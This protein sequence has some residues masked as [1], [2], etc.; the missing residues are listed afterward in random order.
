MGR[1]ITHTQ[2]YTEQT[3]YQPI[4]LVLAR[5]K[6]EK[7]MDAHEEFAG[8]DVGVQRFA[9]QFWPENFR[10]VAH[11]LPFVALFHWAKSAIKGIEQWPLSA[12][13]LRNRKEKFSSENQGT[14]GQ[15]SRVSERE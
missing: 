1:P 11:T 4:P 10:N 2:T 5:D 9:A 13:K 12:F 7:K 15:G 8:S 3:H 14:F 6:T